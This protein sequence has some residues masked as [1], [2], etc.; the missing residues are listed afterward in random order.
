MPLCRRDAI[1][2][3]LEGMFSPRSVAVWVLVTLLAAAGCGWGGRADRDTAEGPELLRLGQSATVQAAA[4]KGADS[5]SESA[6]SDRKGAE[7]R[8]TP[9]GVRYADHDGSGTS[10][11]VAYRA[12]AASGSAL[13]LPPLGETG[14]RWSDGGRIMLR[15]TEGSDSVAGDG[16][17]LASHPRRSAGSDR[18]FHLTFQVPHPGG[19]LLYQGADGRLA[20][21]HLPTKATGEGMA[22]GGTESAA[23]NGRTIVF[24]LTGDGSADIT[25]SNGGRTRHTAQDAALPWVR[26]MTGSTPGG[27]R[28]TAMSQG[29][30][31][32]CEV[33][34]DGR[35]V[36]KQQVSGSDQVKI[37]CGPGLSK[38]ISSSGST[39]WS[40]DLGDLRRLLPD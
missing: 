37:A 8:V 6:R 20:R 17:E 3:L 16:D 5:P 12:S 23:G 10:L 33:R 25:W 28:L 27:A 21:W 15:G 2:A 4:V 18:V 14:F 40:G 24:R 34:V 1:R 9:V 38:A 13:A 22:A 30:S 29:G 31:L 7:L 19:Q 39:S 36:A 26:E 35:I 11:I 32:A